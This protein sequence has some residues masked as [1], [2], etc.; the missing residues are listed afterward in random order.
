MAKRIKLFVTILV[1]TANAS[2]QSNKIIYGNNP[3]AGHYANVNGIKL[4]YETYGSGK[5]LIMLH[6]NGGSI[7]AFKNQIPFFEKYFRVFAIDSRLQGKSGGKPD[8]IS[9]ELMASD[10]NSLLNFLRI[11]SA[12]VLGWSDGGINGLI[13]AIEYSSKVKKLAISGANTTPDSTAFSYSDVLFLKNLVE[14]DTTVSKVTMALN[15]M[16][17]FEPNISFGSLHQIKCPVLVMAG[18]HDIIKP[19]HTLKIYQSIPDAEMCIFPDSHHNALQEH[20]KLFNQ[21]VMTFFEK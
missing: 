14:H 19:E 12:Y 10:F 11:D 3:N 7:E 4:Y 15:K 20:P 8:S 17:L 5:P 18:D 1:I 13:M 21:T 2:A 6:G 16:M 9:Y